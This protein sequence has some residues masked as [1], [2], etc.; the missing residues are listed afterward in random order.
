MIHLRKITEK[1]VREGKNNDG[2]IKY[3]K[4]EYGYDNLKK[5]LM[6]KTK[7]KEKSVQSGHDIRN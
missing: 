7:V 3:V 2:R 1:T 6:R 4:T 5:G